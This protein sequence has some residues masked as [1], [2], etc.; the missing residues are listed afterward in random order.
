M[1]EEGVVLE[2]EPEAAF[3]RGNVRDVDAV[4]QNL[5]RG[6]RFKACDHAKRRGLAAARGPE[7]GEEFAGIDVEIDVVDRHEFFV[8]LDITAADV[9]KTEG[10]RHV[11][12][13]RN[14]REGWLR[15]SEVLPENVRTGDLVSLHF[16]FSKF[17]HKGGGDKK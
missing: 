14:R 6:G 9:L 17:P 12:E 16:V 2:D 10:N 15:C 8:V 5:T 11:S 7:E 1:R 4:D 13:L 3:V